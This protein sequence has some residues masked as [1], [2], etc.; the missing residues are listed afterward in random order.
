N[1]FIIKLEIGIGL[2]CILGDTATCS[3]HISRLRAALFGRSNVVFPHS[4][5][6]APL[7]AYPAFFPHLP[8]RL[9]LFLLLLLGLLQFRC[10]CFTLACL[11]RESLVCTLLRKSSD[12]TLATFFFSGSEGL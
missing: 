10:L 11:S 1:S 2:I 8:G 7:S 9:L 12:G 4:Y 5:D 3:W 6:A